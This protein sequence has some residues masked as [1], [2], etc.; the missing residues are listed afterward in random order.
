MRLE[1]KANMAAFAIT[2]NLYEAYYREFYGILLSEGGG[3]VRTLLSV[4]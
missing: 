4:L 2:R 3:N 1:E